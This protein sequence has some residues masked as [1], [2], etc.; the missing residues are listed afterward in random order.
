MDGIYND[1]VKKKHVQIGSSESDGGESSK[2]RKSSQ[3]L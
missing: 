3:T 1:I 2:F